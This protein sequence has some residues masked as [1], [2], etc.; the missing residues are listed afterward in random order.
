M[1]TDPVFMIR[2]ETVN[3]LVKLSQKQFSQQWLERVVTPK[4][5]ELSKHTR[6]M[7]RIQTIHFIN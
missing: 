4:L 5:D 7:L 6:F 1:T 3:T 2:E